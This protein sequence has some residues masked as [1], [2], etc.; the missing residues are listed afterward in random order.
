M[1]KSIK[2]KLVLQI[3]PVVILVLA[4]TTMV[5]WLMSSSAQQ[6]QA[7]ANGAALAQKYANDFDASAQMDQAIG[8]TIANTMDLY[9]TSNRQEVTSI[10]KNVLE[11]NPLI[12]ATY[13]GYEPN[14]FDGQ[15]ATFANSSGADASGR[16]LPYWN[17]L[18]GNEKLDPLTDMETS[19]YYMAPKKTL[20]DSVIEPYLYQGTLMASYTSPILKD[21][22]FVGIGGVD[23]SL[24]DLDKTV[25]GVKVYDT[26][27]AMLVSNT[28]IFISAKD[29]DLIGNKTL[30]DFGKE[31]NNQVLVTLADNIKAGKEG[32][33]ETSDPFTGKNVVMF[34][35][36]VKTGNWGYVVV[37]PTDEMLAASNNIRNIQIMISVAAIAILAGLIFWI[38]T[39]IAR[40][41]R[42][43]AMA[44]ERI[45]AGDLDV[46][47][48]AASG[49]EVGQTA[50]A[51]TRMVT[52][53]RGMADVAEKMGE[54]DLTDDV[55]PRSEKDVLGRAFA[56]MIASLRDLIGQV[57][58]TSSQ[59]G[60]SSHELAEASA[61]AGA[62]TQQITASIQQVARGA[63]EQSSSIGETSQSVEELAR[64]IDQ[65]AKGAQEQ[66]RGIELTSK[67]V[68]QSLEIIERVTA[69]AQTVAEASSQASKAAKEG[70][71]T[72][73]E[74][75]KAM[76]GV[77]EGAMDVSAHIDQLGTRSEEIG[78]IVET[79][80]DIAEQTNLLALNAAI[81]AARAGEHGKGFAV[82][83]DEVRRLAERSSKAT[84]E[85]SLLIQAVQNDTAQAV[86]SMNSG[87][88]AVEVSSALSQKAG[89][90]LENILSAVDS[91]VARV[92]DIEVA[93]KELGTSSAE[94][95]KA[96]DSVSAIVEEN[97]AAT[98][99]MAANS[100]QV[101]KSVEGIAAIIEENGAAT[102]EV[103]AATEEM[104]A[105][106]QEMSAS[107]QS[108][109]SQAQQLKEQ[110]AKFRTSDKLDLSDQMQLMETVKKAHLNWIQRCEAMIAGKETIDARV[111]AS[112]HDCALGKWYY[113]RGKV[114]W[115]EVAEF[116]ALEGPHEEFHRAVAQVVEAYQRGDKEGAKAN[117]GRL[118]E[119]SHHV[120][121]K[122]DALKH[123]MSAGTSTGVVQKRRQS[124]WSPAEEA[125]PKR[126]G[127]LFGVK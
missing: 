74:A 101:T 45:A 110:V 124:D 113:S 90:A 88:Q 118:R 56:K 117:L 89:E 108:M 27:Y 98:E 115:G 82:V 41:I 3:L 66:A 65:I 15:D 106:V 17:K 14:A 18:S 99:Q 37:A 78:N 63:Q 36:P 76:D 50:S 121:A 79:I 5:T 91:A 43:L 93:A 40:P 53:L 67:S 21:G 30:A 112:F 9:S 105:Q 39:R 26:G 84:K 25:S 59:V 95:V 107:A 7:Y 123:R 111:A 103:N 44:A 22:K 24:A 20:T 10:L 47:V 28:G 19:D 73:S 72:V 55:T 52:Y 83:A 75:I 122:I 32:Y 119:S 70:A 1:K 16:F 77:K 31:K 49:D 46:K 61:Q 126:L 6:E 58:Y 42:S 80:D 54:G 100:G 81:E 94:V 102:Q 8:R 51:F 64:A 4:A 34:Y 48:D 87:A 92:R 38:A 62:A 85:I 23:V 86:Q 60:E 68:N 29:K 71:A 13:V 127:G 120:I 114:E 35:A 11:K 33:V 96:M 109:A 69:S 116:G 12:L 57:A 125:Q 2:M 104:T 97:T